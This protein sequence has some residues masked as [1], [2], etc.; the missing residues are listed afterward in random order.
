MTIPKYEELGKRT[1]QILTGYYDQGKYYVK[2]NAKTVANNCQF[3]SRIDP[4][5]N[6]ASFA[7]K[8]DISGDY[9]IQ[10]QMKWNTDNVLFGEVA[11]VDSL[12]LGSRVGLTGSLQPKTGELGSA[13][14]ANLMRSSLR[15]DVSMV[16]EKGNT[17]CN[18]SMVM[19]FGGWLFGYQCQGTHWNEM[20]KTGVPCIAYIDGNIEASINKS[21]K[22][23]MGTLLN[24]AKSDLETTARFNYD[25]QKSSLEL[26][27]VL[28]NFCGHQLM[29]KIDTNT[30]VGVGLIVNLSPG[31]VITLNGQMSGKTLNNP[32]TSLG[33]E[34][35]F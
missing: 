2:I 4:T 16:N 26:G 6:R 29:A 8:M 18:N 31:I 14:T 27:C 30:V 23:L 35:Q 20:I 17:E 25:G 34:F 5:G 32:K 3:E 21:G 11:L 12:F 24:K 19:K 9:G 15:A 1:N 22:A 28:K 33:V 13:L 10:M 7:T